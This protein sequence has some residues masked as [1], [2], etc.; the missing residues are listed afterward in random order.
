MRGAT[1]VAAIVLLLV[2]SPARAQQLVTVVPEAEFPAGIAFS[3]EGSRM[4]Y[5]ERTGE[6][7]VVEN[8]KQDDDPITEI[9]TTTAGETG[10]LGIAVS[11][12]D[13]WIYAFATDPGGATNR[14][15]RAPAT[16]GDAEVIVSDLPAN[17]YHNGGGVAF[18]ADGMLLVSNGET[19]DS[20]RSQDPD[21]L[22]GKLYRFTPD[23]DPAPQNPFGP[24]I[25]IGLRNPFGLTVDPVSGAAFVTDNGPEQEDEVNR[26]DMGGN[27]GWP[28]TVGPAPEAFTP[29]GPGTYHDPVW[30]HADIVVPTGIAVADPENAAEDV[31]GDVFFGT[32]GE[33]TIR[34]IE[35]NDARDAAVSDEVY[36]DVGEP[37]VALEWGPGGLYFSTPTAIKMIPL[38][39]DGGVPPIQPGGT[40]DFAPFVI[41]SIVVIALGA[42]LLVIAGRA[43]RGPGEPGPR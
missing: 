33:Q 17:V 27:Y 24:S 42:L 3:S 15:Y 11:P 1:L 6:I 39:S 12:D 23:G 22:G 18:D 28:E 16:G 36:L 38:A 34:R 37:V 40:R 20:S 5:S 8:G 29:S 35:L 30:H 13:R 26:V 14:V 4:Y 9:P 25:A 2:A 10:L 31:A 32:F 41:G 19:H 7:R 21:A 43:R